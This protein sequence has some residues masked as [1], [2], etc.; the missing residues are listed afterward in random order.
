MS[1][2]D[3]LIALFTERPTR[4]DVTWSDLES[5]MSKLDF[6]KIKDKGGRVAFMKSGKPETLIRIHRP[7]PENTLKRYVVEL[8]CEKIKGE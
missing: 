4:A 7:H 5:L 8:I 6:E 2:K 1:K 3:K